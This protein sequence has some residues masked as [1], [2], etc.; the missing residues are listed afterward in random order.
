MR[1]TLWVA[2]IAAAAL[3]P[4]LAFAQNS[5]EQQKHDQR[6]AGTV[7]GG[8]AG[9]VLGNAV[10]RGGGKT[11]GTILGA[12]AGA[13][14]GNQLARSNADCS[15]AYGYYDNNNQWHATG[16]QTSDAAGYYDRNGAWV[17]GAPDGYADTNGRWVPASATSYYDADGQWMAAPAS[18]YYDNG[19]WIQG[20]VRGHYDSNGRWMSGDPMGHRDS[21]GMWIADAQPG[22]YGTDGRWRAGPARGYY[23]TRGLWVSSDGAVVVSSGYS[24]V[25]TDRWADAGADTR[26]RENW[27]EQRIR[28]NSQQNRLSHREARSALMTLSSIRQEDQRM[29]RGGELNPRNQAYIQSR[30]DSLA[31][32]IRMDR[33]D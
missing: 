7:I 21:A 29:R 26:A 15:H 18:G 2:G 9:A 22:Y 31:A 12:V 19:R 13:A 24:T 25:R 3:F 28:D 16:V 11:G 32:T 20:P 4:S 1:K 33:Q 30:L 10:S 14:V 8:V 27:L 6:T 23:D 17:Q 5:C